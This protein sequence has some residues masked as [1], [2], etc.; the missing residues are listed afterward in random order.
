MS[1]LIW[2]QHVDRALA[3]RFSRAQRTAMAQALKLTLGYGIARKQFA[4]G[5]SDRVLRMLLD[6]GIGEIQT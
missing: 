6:R 2:L 1:D 5:A 3:K 4:K